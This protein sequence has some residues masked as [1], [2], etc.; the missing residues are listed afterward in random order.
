MGTYREKELGYP[1]EYDR[2]WNHKII[3]KKNQD[4]NNLYPIGTIENVSK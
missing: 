3:N 2:S 4:K 1:F